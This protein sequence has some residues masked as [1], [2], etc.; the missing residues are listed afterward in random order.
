MYFKKDTAYEFTKEEDTEFMHF[1]I[2][3][4]APIIK[5]NLSK[6]QKVVEYLKA[7]KR[8][9]SLTINNIYQET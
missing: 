4:V 3:K 5:S 9:D 7:N 1:S 8:I 2:D 6:M